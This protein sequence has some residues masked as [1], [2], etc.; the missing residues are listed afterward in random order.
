MKIVILLS[1]VMLAACGITP[2]QRAQL[3]AGLVCL[4]DAAGNVTATDAASVARSAGVTV[5][6]DAA[7]AAAIRGGVTTPIAA[8]PA[9]PATPAAPVAR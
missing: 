4:A 8:S 6:T 9:T 1:L 7:C 5:L 2:A 3:Q